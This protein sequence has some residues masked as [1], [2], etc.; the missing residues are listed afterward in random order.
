MKLQQGDVKLFQT[1]DN[2]DISVIDGVVEMSGGLETAAYLSLFGGND[3]D[4]GRDGNPLEWWGNIGENIQARQYR[5]ETQNLI[6][7]LPATTGNL[8]RIEDAAKRDL[9]WFL[10]VGVASSVAV[11]VIIPGLNRIKITIE[12]EANGEESSFSF[13]ENWKAAV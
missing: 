2:G 5:S 11:G 12:I 1:D 4:D 8:Q 3:D 7:G 10:S 6:Q 9:D 13:T